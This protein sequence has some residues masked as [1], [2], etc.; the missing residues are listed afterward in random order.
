MI[1]AMARRKPK[2]KRSRRKKSGVSIIGLA[3]TAVLTSVVTQTLFNV[4]AYDF[5]MA[6]SVPS[7]NAMTI[8]E[9]LSPSG[10]QATGMVAQ[11][12][13][14]GKTSYVQGYSPTLDLVAQNLKANWVMGGLQMI[15]IPAA[16]K[17]GKT[18]ARPAIS[19]ANRLLGKA[20]I[21]STVKV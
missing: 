12:G 10:T 11:K 3:E 2:Q 16:F 1:C 4:N 5:F 21:S 17:A 19:R 8:R 6:A 13:A 7:G 14:Y 20:N 15:L 18:I 9:L